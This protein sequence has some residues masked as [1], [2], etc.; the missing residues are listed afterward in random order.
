MKATIEFQLP[1]DQEQYNFA[2]KG[3]DYLCV[4]CEFDEFLRQKIKYS[5]LQEN[6]YTL[7]EDTREQLRQMLFERGI[8]L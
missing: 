7:L 6:E 5:E 3:F 4:L 2:N 1:E 8:S